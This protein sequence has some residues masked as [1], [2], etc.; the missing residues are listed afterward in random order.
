MAAIIVSD[1][2]SGHTVR[3]LRKP[4]VETDERGHSVWA[5]PV[6]SA[7]LELVNTTMLKKI[8]ESDDE[9]A[10]KHIEEASKGKDGVLA[11]DPDSNRFEIID[12]D[13]LQAALDSA[14]S[15]PEQLR[16]AD[17]VLQPLNELV[18]EEEDE[19]SLV[20]TQMLRRILESDDP[21]ANIDPGDADDVGG[22]FDPYNS[23]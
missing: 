23:R 15:T 2:D 20:S 8:L 21:E 17:V 6:E 22:G 11:R 10:R 7:E 16:P 9:H 18:N 14:S 19:L 13:D 4:K 12:D 5:D 1:D 3:I